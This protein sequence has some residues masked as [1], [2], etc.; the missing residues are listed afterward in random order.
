MGAMMKCAIV[1]WGHAILLLSSNIIY[2]SWGVRWKGRGI[3]NNF[4]EGYVAF[5]SVFLSRV[6]LKIFTGVS[7]ISDRLKCYDGSLL[8]T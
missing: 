8:E 4:A 2:L 5:F 1:A 7:I 3:A 6:P